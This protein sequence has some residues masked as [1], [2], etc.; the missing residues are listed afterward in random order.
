[1]INK[2]NTRNIILHAVSIVLLVLLSVKITSSGMAATVLIA[3][4]FSLDIQVVIE[5][6]WIYVQNGS[7]G[8]SKFQV[9]LICNS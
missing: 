8:L 6:D 7:Y 3:L 1:M 5:C 9:R 4:S 2:I